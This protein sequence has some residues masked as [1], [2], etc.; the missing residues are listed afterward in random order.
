M[1]L[2]TIALKLPAFDARYL[3]YAAGKSL[4]SQLEEI[5][6]L[7]SGENRKNLTGIA[8]IDFFSS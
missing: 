2:S 7:P 6:K 8:S 1:T 3:C 5:V 4:R